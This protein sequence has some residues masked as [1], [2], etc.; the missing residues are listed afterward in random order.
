MAFGA[1]IL[2]PLVAAV[3]ALLA[4]DLDTNKSWSAAEALRVP[5][6]GVPPATTAVL[7]PAGHYV[8]PATA[9]ASKSFKSESSAFAAAHK[10][11]P[12]ASLRSKRKASSGYS[13]NVPDSRQPQS[14][15]DGTM[16]I[17]S[18]PSGAGKTTMIRA[19]R[20]VFGDDQ[21][22]QTVL[23]T[24]R[25]PREGERDGVDYHYV[26]RQKMK[27]MIAAGEFVQH[28]EQYG[29]MYG[30]THV[31][32]RRALDPERLPR[33]TMLDIDIKDLDTWAAS[34]YHEQTKYLMITPTR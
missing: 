33:V 6:E 24:T 22:T 8:A 21:I 34:V 1:R 7:T 23:H 15:I 10:H 9:S 20:K 28:V 31:A 12:T 2:P 14:N 11:R 29:N 16:V 30:T 25:A 5:A 18:G 3:L 27:D 26:T 32:L 17:F 13:R 19:M 4:T